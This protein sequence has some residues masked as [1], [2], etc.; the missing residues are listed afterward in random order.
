MNH[1]IKV[2]VSFG[3]NSGVIT[4]LGLI[5][6]LYSG[7]QSALAVI[8][9]IITI[10]IADA[11]SDALGIHVS[12]ESEG[13]HTS[14]EIWQSTIATF[15]TKFFIAMSFLVPVLLLP[16]G[17]AVLTSVVWGMLLVANFSYT[18]ARAQNKSGLHAVTEH[19]TIAVLVIIITY[20]VGV[21]VDNRFGP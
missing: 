14:L 18:M 7:T 6:G 10:A 8:G 11:F 9:G 5:V 19:L 17:Q 21:L 1:S 20:F 15:L 12:E 13:V 4:T 16:L 2:G 3:L